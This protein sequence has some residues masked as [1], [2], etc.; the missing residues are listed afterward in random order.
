MN[1]LIFQLYKLMS[2]PVTVMKY[3][4]C[5]KLLNETE[6]HY[7]V[8][9]ETKNTRKKLTLVLLMSVQSSQEPRIVWVAQIHLNE[10]KTLF[11]G[12]LLRF[13]PKLLIK[14]RAKSWSEVL[15]YP[16]NFFHGKT[17]TL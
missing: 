17:A 2:I 4:C 10:A 3:K 12:L 15:P 16:R 7:S 8:S 11:L 6:H 5:S 13:S 1:N 14:N 9:I